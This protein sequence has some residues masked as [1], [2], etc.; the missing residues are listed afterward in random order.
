MND[1]MRGMELLGRA[2]RA[3]HVDDDALAA[4]RDRIRLIFSWLC[5][6]TLFPFA[7]MH[8][9]HANW[10]MFGI[11]AT[12]VGVILLN[13]WAMR[14]NGVPLIPFWSLGC[15]MV[16]GS[17]IS[18]MLQGVNGVLW[19]FPALFMFFFVLSRSTAMLLGLALL[20]GITAASA[21][22]LGWPLAL[23]IFMSLGFVLIMIN[24][25]LNVVSELQ[26]ALMA[27]AITDPL[28][29]AFNRRHLQ[30]HLAQRVVPGARCVAG[31]ALLAIDIDNF[32][33][34]NDEHGH[35]VGDSV[36]CRLVSTIDA[37]KR[38]GDLLFRT[39]G[40]E[41][42]LLLPRITVMAAQGVAESLREC[43]A[44]AELMPGRTITVSIGVS[45]L[46]P[47]QSIDAWTQAADAALYE[48]KRLGRN[49]VVVSPAL[50][51]DVL[52]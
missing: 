35:A 18:V 41:F 6:I 34:I 32:K 1:D 8:L 14:R 37:R 52:I 2:R 4:H 12:L 33:R 22:A 30:D 19:A 51:E 3:L 25:V 26:R 21:M 17:C 9:V 23:R 27:Q 50:I 46:S 7:V 11:N 45:A 43:L 24:I 20:L 13:V 15:L 39:G 31:D 36:L 5:A 29:G 40:E 10:L 42:V 44:Q 38:S 48:A 47:G 16:G 28:T 49:R